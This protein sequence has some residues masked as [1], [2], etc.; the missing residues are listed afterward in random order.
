M[1]KIR[2]GAGSKENI[3]LKQG[4]K[5]L[6]RREQAAAKYLEIEQGA[7]EITKEQEENLKEQKHREMKKSSENS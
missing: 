7:R 6:L 3:V 5:E 4:S 2:K 1:P